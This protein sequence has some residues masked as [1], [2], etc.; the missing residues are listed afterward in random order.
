MKIKITEIEATAEELKASQT[1]ASS[2]SNLLRNAF[3]VG[4]YTEETDEQAESEE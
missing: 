4:N 3:M 2:F 1:L